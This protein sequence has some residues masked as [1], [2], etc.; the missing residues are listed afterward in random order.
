MMEGC[1]YS[2]IE[3]GFSCSFAE[4]G[5]RFALSD[6]LR[7]RH[8]IQ[9]T[10]AKE[11]AA[12]AQPIATPAMTPAE[13][14]LLGGFADTVVADELGVVCGPVEDEVVVVYGPVEDESVVMD[15]ALVDV[16]SASEVY[17]KP[18]VGM[19]KIETKLSFGGALNVSLDGS[20]QFVWPS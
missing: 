5:D 11:M 7:L 14:P 18:L 13:R 2:K 4:L 17:W 20:P 15:R 1:N 3:A 12:I 6:R 8:S 19:E 9:N 16:D 10:K